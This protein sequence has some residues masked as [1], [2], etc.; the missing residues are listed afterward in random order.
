[1]LSS[2]SE[3]GGPR[4][5]TLIELLVALALL[6]IMS[7]MTYR[8]VSSVLDA[9]KQVKETARHWQDIAMFFEQ[10]DADAQQAADRPIRDARGD[11]LGA[12][13]L[14][15]SETQGVDVQVEWSRLGD[16]GVPRSTTRRVGYRVRDGKLEYLQWP[17]LDRAPST[18]FKRIPLVDQVRELRLRCLTQDG[19]WLQ[20]WPIP[21]LGVHLPRALEVVLVFDDGSTVTRLIA[22]GAT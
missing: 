1:M 17:V 15:S 13:V 3:R 14:R 4:G 22:L 21:G 7:V 5:F 10:I 20:T 16:V 19:R 6:A 12:W 9:E 8:V 11:L 2:Q 18:E